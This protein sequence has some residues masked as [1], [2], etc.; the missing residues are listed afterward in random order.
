MVEKYENFLRKEKTF[1]MSEIFC[2]D[3]DQINNYFRVKYTS[4]QATKSSFDSPRNS[5]F[6]VVLPIDGKKLPRLKI[7]V[8]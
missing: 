5:P 7:I 2:C 8:K 3:D 6:S 1:L 4:K